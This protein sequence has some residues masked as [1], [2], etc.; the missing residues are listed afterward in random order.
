MSEAVSTDET[1][2][3]CARCKREK[4]AEDFRIDKKR[5]A[6]HSWCRACERE[7][8]LDR[9]HNG[10]KRPPSES[11][12]E[13]EARLLE[14]FAEWLDRQRDLLNRTVLMIPNDAEEPQLVVFPEGN[15]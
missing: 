6:L 8:N 12:A 9:Y 2:K 15:Q 14:G 13:E 10:N 5:L 1:V 7:D 4:Y 3:R 11:E